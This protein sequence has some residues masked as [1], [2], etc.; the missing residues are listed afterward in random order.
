MV[1]TATALVVLATSGCGA[2]DATAVQPVSG[3]DLPPWQG[4]DKEL[5]GDEIDPV[6]LGLLPPR[7]PRKDEVLAARAQR[8]EIVGKVKIQ[9]FSSDDRGGEITYRLTLRFLE[10]TL[11]PTEL[12]DREFEV[13][14]DP[15]DGAFGLIKAVDAGIKARTFIGFVRRF[16]GVDDTIDAHFYLAPDSPEVASAI[17]EA[18]AVRELGPR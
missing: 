3:R 13:E 4:M 14:V 6:A 5:L 17:Q 1:A 8:A 15:R 18:A 12:V 7:D 16:G 9:T 10:P 2:S 11:L